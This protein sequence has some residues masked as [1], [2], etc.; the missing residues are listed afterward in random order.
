MKLTSTTRQPRG[1]APNLG[2]SRTR[3]RVIGRLV[4]TRSARIWPEEAERMVTPA[5][6]R[7]PQT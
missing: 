5:D 1:Q 3:A 7:R 4:R 6:L 2:L